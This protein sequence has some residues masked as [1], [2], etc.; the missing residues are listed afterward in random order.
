MK[1]FSGILLS[2]YMFIAA[3]HIYALANGQAVLQTL[4]KCLLMPFLIMYV[5]LQARQVLSGYMLLLFAL[6]FSWVGDMLLLNSENE[7]YFMLGLGA[8]LL[9]HLAYIFCFRKLRYNRLKFD[10]TT[11]IPFMLYA[12]VLFILILP[13]LGD[14]LFP[15][16]MYALTITIMGITAALRKKTT[17]TYSYILVLIGAV[18]FIVSDSIIAI[19]KFKLPFAGAPI[20]IMLTYCIAQ[21]LIVSGCLSHK[22]MA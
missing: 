2:A 16:L 6:L 12:A 15:V 19:N 14:M 5:V 11:A 20:C 18:S 4:S 9:A 1:F 22:Q 3:A 7:L 8:F 13:G 21:Y 10:I 17:N